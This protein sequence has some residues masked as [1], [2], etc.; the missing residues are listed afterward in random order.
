MN[1]QFDITD[2]MLSLSPVTYNQYQVLQQTCFHILN[3]NEFLLIE[4]F[5]NT[6]FKD[7]RCLLD[8]KT[9]MP[10]ELA[11]NVFHSCQELHD[12]QTL[13][14]PVDQE[15]SNLLGAPTQA[16]PVYI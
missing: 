7:M 6:I 1:T 5:I 14:T 2:Q 11:T 15:S 10:S 8:P 9:Q 13:K 4:K 16:T 3:F 12:M